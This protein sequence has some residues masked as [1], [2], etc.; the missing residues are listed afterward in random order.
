MKWNEA[1]DESLTQAQ[2]ELHS[3]GSSIHHSPFERGCCTGD[4]FNKLKQTETEEHELLPLLNEQDC[5]CVCICVC[6]SQSP[7]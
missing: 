4:G 6:T 7:D 2:I 3:K 1:W 5:V